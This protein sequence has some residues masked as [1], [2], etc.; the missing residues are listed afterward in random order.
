MGWRSDRCP[1]F[2]SLYDLNPKILQRFQSRLLISRLPGVKSNNKKLQ[3]YEKA[4]F[5]CSFAHPC[6]KPLRGF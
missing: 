1:F 5:G 4:S 6:N 2:C 3:Y